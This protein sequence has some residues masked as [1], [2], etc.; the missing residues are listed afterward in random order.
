MRPARQIGAGPTGGGREVIAPESWEAPEP[1]SG[2]RL[3]ETARVP[4][5]LLQQ[6]PG[7]RIPQGCHGLDH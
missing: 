6:S 4:P 1:A 7:E 2:E 3:G 5:V